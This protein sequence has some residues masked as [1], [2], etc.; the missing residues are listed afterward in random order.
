MENALSTQ[1]APVATTMAPAKSLIQPPEPLMEIQRTVPPPKIMRQVKK[2]ELLQLK[3]GGQPESLAL[4]RGR[5]A[6][7]PSQDRGG[8]NLRKRPTIN[9]QSQVAPKRRNKAVA[10]REDQEATKPGDRRSPQSLLH[11]SVGHCLHHLLLD[12]ALA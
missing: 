4:K 8:P 10:I 3:P 2:K 12:P 9:R 6:A 5:P 1:D 7:K 11:G